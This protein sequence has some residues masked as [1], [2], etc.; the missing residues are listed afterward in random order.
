M[1]SVTFSKVGKSYGSTRVVT[2]LDLELA[3]G[4]ITVLVGPSGCGKTTSLRML[5]GLE[6]VS[7]GP[8]HIGDRD[9]TTLEPKDRDIAMVFQ[10][11]ALYPHLSVRENI[12]FPLRAKRCGAPT[13]SPRHWVWMHWSSANPRTCP[14]ASNSGSRSGVPSSA[15]PRCS[16]STSR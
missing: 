12:A 8:I 9:V 7:S 14:V 4:S 10:N 6:G 3:D 1:A 15:S 2:D 11:Y 16:C 13:R 5:A